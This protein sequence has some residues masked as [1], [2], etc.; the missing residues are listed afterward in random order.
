MVSTA[1]VA[2]LRLCDGGWLCA[3]RPHL[4]D[5][6]L[7]QNL[8]R[9][10]IYQYDDYDR[11]L[12]KERVAQFRDQVTRYQADQLSEEEFLPLRLQHAFV[13]TK[14]CLH[15]ACGDSIRCFV[16]ESTACVGLY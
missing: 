8:L 4:F 11:A 10:F 5:L 1:L 15:V 9:I 14:A 13:P 3:Q 16:S 6:W 2:W 7:T 12:V